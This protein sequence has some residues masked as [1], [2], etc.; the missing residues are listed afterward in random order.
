VDTEA[1][2]LKVGRAWASGGG[3]VVCIRRT[4]HTR[5]L[6][7]EIEHLNQVVTF[8]NIGQSQKDIME[9]LHA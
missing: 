6:G 9:F 2:Y 5:F 1:T 3:W 7:S 4:T 8:Q